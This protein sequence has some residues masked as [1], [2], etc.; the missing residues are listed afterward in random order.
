MRRVTYALLVICLLLAGPHPRSRRLDS[1]RSLAAAAGAS[2]YVWVPV[3]A[4]QTAP[5][6]TRIEFSPVPEEEGSGILISLLGSGE[7]SYTVDYGDGKTER[8]TATLP[9]RMRHDYAPDKQYMVVATPDAPCEGVARA[10]LD[11]RAIARGIWKVSVEPGPATDAPEII[12]TI[13]GRGACAVA[14]SFGDGKQQKV[15]GTLPAKVS[16]TYEK[17]GTYELHAVAADPCRGE[18]RLSVDVRR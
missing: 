4:A 17:P 7:C 16:H 14:L 10:Q 6:I 3:A 11:I 15:E 13:H 1:L 18:V 8:R 5:R 12:A 9:D 2:L